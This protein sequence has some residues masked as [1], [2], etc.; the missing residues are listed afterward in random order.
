MS[1]LSQQTMNQATGERIATTYAVDNRVDFVTL[2]LIELLTIID[3]R[4]PAV[5]RCTETL[6]KRRNN[7]LEAKLLT[8]LL[9]DTLVTS[10]VSLS[11]LHVSIGLEAKAKLCILLVANAD[12]DILHQRAH[13][14]DSLLTSP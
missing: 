10:S 9:E 2:G 6:A 3:K 13:D 1:W 5:E 8:H 7:I 14:G 11:T 12:I 4:L